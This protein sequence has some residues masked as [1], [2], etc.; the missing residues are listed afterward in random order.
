VVFIA[1]FF[2]TVLFSIS[3][4]PLDDNPLFREEAGADFFY[5]NQKVADIFCTNQRV[6]TDL[7]SGDVVID[8]L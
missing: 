5:A 4:L 1:V 3:F 2:I 6:A 8:F 7:M